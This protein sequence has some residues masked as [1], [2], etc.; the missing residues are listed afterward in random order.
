[1]DDPPLMDHLSLSLQLAEHPSATEA[2]G[3]IKLQE[4]FDDPMLLD[5]ARERIATDPGL[6]YVFTKLKERRH[7]AL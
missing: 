4:T 2:I 7:Y 5:E 3:I 1:M 6:T